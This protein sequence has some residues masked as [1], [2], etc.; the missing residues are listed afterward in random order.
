MTGQ[1]APNTRTA[2][3]PPV[4]LLAF[5]VCACLAVALG[6]ALL[7]RK[8]AP[9]AGLTFTAVDYSALEGWQDDTLSGFDLAFARSC[10]ALLAMPASKPLPGAAIGG[11]AGDWHGP[12]LAAN[13][14]SG[15]ALKRVIEA[16]F[17]PYS[18]SI[19]GKRDGV[20]TGYYEPLLE[21]SYTRT[22][23]YQTP[24]YS[25]PTDLVSV[26]LGQFRADLAGRRIAG[27]VEGGRLVPY[28][29]REAITSGQF[30]GQ[31]PAPILYVRDPVSAFF[32]H[33]QGSGRARLPSGELVGVGYAG[34]NGH[35]YFA[36][37]RLLIDEGHIAR[38]DM[39]LQ[40]IRAWLAEHPDEA[41]RVMNSNPS[42]IF[43]RLL[44]SGA[45]P[46]GSAGVSL[47]PQRSL[48]V[49]RKHLSMHLPV[50]LVTDVPDVSPASS[51]DSAADGLN[52]VAFA[53]LMMAQDTGGA[54][55]GEVR[56]DV[57]W[58][59]GREAEDIAGRMNSKGHYYILLPRSRTH[60][61]GCGLEQAR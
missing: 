12:C 55:A 54:I 31:E 42:F 13:G 29:D 37:G 27:R 24:L 52:T 23:L 8:A 25:L 10:E 15:A 33:I 45:G 47:T 49:D 21:A 32:L 46:F 16:E 48:A 59:P 56:G 6:A 5:A 17:Q 22:S 3:S 57:F 26:D 36:I 7:L 30:G 60:C 40:A 14:L 9:A 53:K 18:V 38:R 44:E 19:A 50:F 11:V 41:E 58:G 39:S 51:I 35:P 43:F 2:S 28:A 1:P 34:Q 4:W 20:F 61:T